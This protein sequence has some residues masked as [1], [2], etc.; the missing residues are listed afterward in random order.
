MYFEIIWDTITLPEQEKRLFFTL[1]CQYLSTDFCDV[2]DQGTMPLY[3]DL[4]Q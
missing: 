4:V 3:I 1:Y 2:R